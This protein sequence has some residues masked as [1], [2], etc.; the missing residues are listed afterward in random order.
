MAVRKLESQVL[1]P[2]DPSITSENDWPEFQLRNAEVRNDA[3]RL[4]NLLHTDDDRPV[5]ITGDFI[6]FNTL[7]SHR[8]PYTYSCFA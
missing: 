4:F 3:G 2:R 8:V 1:K 6:A 7:Q 5:I